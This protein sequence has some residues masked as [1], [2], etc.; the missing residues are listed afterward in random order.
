ME[1]FKATILSLLILSIL[2]G[3]IHIILKRLFKNQD[4]KLVWL[5]LL[6]IVTWIDL[7]GLQMEW[8]RLF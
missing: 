6:F 7:I 1:L 4:I 3:V 5:W 2:V 8:W